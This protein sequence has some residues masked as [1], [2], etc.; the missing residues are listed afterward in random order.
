M[1]VKRCLKCRKP[2]FSYAG[3]I[4]ICP[5]CDE[6]IKEKKMLYKEKMDKEG[7]EIKY[8]IDIGMG[9][10]RCGYSG[11]NSEGDGPCTNC[12]DFPEGGHCEGGDY[13]PDEVEVGC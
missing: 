7:K 9:C 6:L 13:D 2:N 4:S 8:C 1:K 3:G 5:E 10:G 12:L 11:V